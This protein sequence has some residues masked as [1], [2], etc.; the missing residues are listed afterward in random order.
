MLK[1][2]KLAYEG[3]SKKEVEIEDI[4]NEISRVKIDNLNT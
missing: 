1:Q 3:I 4:S 2:T